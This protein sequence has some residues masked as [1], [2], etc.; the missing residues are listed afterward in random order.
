MKP[1]MNQITEH[2][3]NFIGMDKPRISKFKT[4]KKLLEIPW[5]KSF[6]DDPEFYRYSMDDE[7]LM[8][9][10]KKGKDWWPVGNIKNP[11]SVDL[12]KWVK[13]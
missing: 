12:P 9:E 1:S 11:A 6:S 10:Y 3:P 8:A 13:R 4:C 2:V 7:S 5:V